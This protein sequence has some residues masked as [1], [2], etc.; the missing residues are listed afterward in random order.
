[1]AIV[2]TR[3]PLTWA[4]SVPRTF[5]IRAHRSACQKEQL[6]TLE[7]TQPRQVGSNQIAKLRHRPD[8]VADQFAIV[9][10]RR[11]SDRGACLEK[12]LVGCITPPMPSL[13]KGPGADAVDLSQSTRALGLAQLP[14]A[15][16]VIVVR[17]ADGH[18]GQRKDPLAPTIE[19]LDRATENL[20]VVDFR[21]Q[22]HLGVTPDMGS[23]EPVEVLV[24]LSRSWIHEHHASGLRIGRVHGH[25]QRRQSLLLDSGPIVVSQIRERHVVAVHEGKSIVVVFH[26]QTATQPFRS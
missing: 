23:L 1:M 18:H 25:V 12:Q 5:Q 11:W 22:Y 6:T 8:A 24:D 7:I 4:I 10:V 20:T 19:V 14:S 2:S 9:V 16:I 13:V 21:A 26:V 3:A 17:E 15:A